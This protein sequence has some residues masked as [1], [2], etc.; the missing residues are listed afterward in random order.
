MTTSCFSFEPLNNS[1]YKVVQ[2]DSLKELPFIYVKVYPTLL[3]LID[4]GCGENHARDASVQEKS[5]RR[6]IETKLLEAGKLKYVD[7]DA[8]QEKNKHWLVFITH[9]H[10]DHIGG[11]SEFADDS[12]VFISGNDK[13]YIL[14]DLGCNSLC[15]AFNI[16]TP[17]FKVYHWLQQKEHLIFNGVDLKIQALLTPGHTPDEIALYDVEEHVLFAGDSIYEQLPIYII[18]TSNMVDYIASIELMLEYVQD[19]N[20]QLEPTGKRVTTAS[21]HITDKADTEKLLV[22]TKEAFWQTLKGEAV[23]T[24]Q[25]IMRGKQLVFY[26]NQSKNVGFMCI[27]SKLEEAKKHFNFEWQMPA[28]ILLE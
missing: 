8:N 12:S 4:T 20:K 6:F 2:D 5:I 28:P 11:L 3:L 15:C 9:T 19:Q 25:D 23:L 24:K 10:Y 16:P 7:P 13:N 17:K 21:G 27:D 22:E 14:K 1:T 18:E 26:F